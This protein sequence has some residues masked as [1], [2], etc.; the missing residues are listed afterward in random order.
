[1]LPLAINGFKD[2]F[3]FF[4]ETLGEEN[5]QLYFIGAVFELLLKRISKE[6]N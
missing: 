3:L 2:V 6:Q 1:M 5:F 4:L